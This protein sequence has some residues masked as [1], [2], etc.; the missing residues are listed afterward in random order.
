MVVVIFFFVFLL[1]IGNYV[2]VEGNVEF[3]MKWCGV[4]LLFCIVVFG[5]VMFGS[6]G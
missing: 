5:M 6:V 3:I 2:Y 4:L 1:V